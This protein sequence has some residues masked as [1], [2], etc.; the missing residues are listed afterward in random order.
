MR[1]IKVIERSWLA[2][3]QR[4]L[5]T[6]TD[7]STQGHCPRPFFF[8][9]PTDLALKDKEDKDENDLTVTL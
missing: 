7:T 1:F 6:N 5:Q 4:Q 9:I 3:V 8:K 2:L